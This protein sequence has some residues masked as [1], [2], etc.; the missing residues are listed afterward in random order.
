MLF[1]EG[2]ARFFPVQYLVTSHDV[3]WIVVTVHLYVRGSRF[4]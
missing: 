2:I 3:Y 4:E 1:K